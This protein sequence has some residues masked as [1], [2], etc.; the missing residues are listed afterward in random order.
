MLVQCCQISPSGY[1]SGTS[2]LHR[3]IVGSG[4]IKSFLRLLYGRGRSAVAA[5]EATEPWARLGFAQLTVAAG[6]GEGGGGGRRVDHGVSITTRSS[7][8]ALP[9]P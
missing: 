6:T 7:Y 8:V 2:L 4:G 1:A 9:V 3:I 5:W